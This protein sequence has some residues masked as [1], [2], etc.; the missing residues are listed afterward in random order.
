MEWWS[1]WAHVASKSEDPKTKIVSYSIDYNA[2]TLIFD[3]F[4]V[5]DKRRGLEILSEIH[6]HLTEPTHM[7]DEEVFG[8]E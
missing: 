2:V 7:T 1:V 3:A 6:R 8:W 5:E 4:G